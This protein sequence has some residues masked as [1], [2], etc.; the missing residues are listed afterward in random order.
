M[1]SLNVLNSVAKNIYQLKA[2]F[3]TAI[4]CVRE[5]DV[6]IVPARQAADRIFK[7]TPIHTSLIC[8]IT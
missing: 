2:L 5:Q 6:T 3:K 1:F 8:Q 7:L 4:S